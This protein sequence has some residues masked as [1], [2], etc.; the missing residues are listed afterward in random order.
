MYRFT[1]AVWSNKLHLQ[2]CTDSRTLLWKN[3]HKE[4]GTRNVHYRDFG[5]VILRP[6]QTRFRGPQIINPWK[7]EG[8]EGVGDGNDVNDEII[9]IW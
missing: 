5:I 8:G 4:N 3:N 2:I 1:H 9:L 7:C 6:E